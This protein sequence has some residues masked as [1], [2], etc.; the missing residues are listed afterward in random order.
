MILGPIEPNNKLIGKNPFICPE[1][2]LSKGYKIQ[3]G[4]DS[5]ENM[6]KNGDKG[7]VIDMSDH[8]LDYYYQGIRIQPRHFG[9]CF[10]IAT[11]FLR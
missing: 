1:Y 4:D 5:N 10:N 6:G 9:C 11:I 7:K 2:W 8:A 3:T